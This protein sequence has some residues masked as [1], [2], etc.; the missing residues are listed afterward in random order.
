MRI[1][2]THPQ[3]IHAEV[4]DY[5]SPPRLLTIVYGSPNPVLRKILWKDLN[6]NRLELVEPWMIVGDFNSVMDAEEISSQNVLVSPA[7]FFNMAFL[8]WASQDQNLHG[9]GE[10]LQI[11]SLVRDMT[12]P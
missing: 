10:Q 3:F 7:G 4:S 8:T 11:L 2:K 9:L 1:L 6:H 12:G 5:A